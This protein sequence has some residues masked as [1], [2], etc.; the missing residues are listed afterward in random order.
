MAGKGNRTR[1]KTPAESD[2]LSPAQAGALLSATFGR[3]VPSRTVQ[4]W[5]ARSHQP[6]DHVRV[7]SKILIHRSA[8][9][10][11]LKRDSRKVGA[12]AGPADQHGPE[13]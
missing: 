1:V 4:S 6:L 8:L 5:V 7:G 3:E 10:D 11:W 12:S 13:E 9:F 2:W